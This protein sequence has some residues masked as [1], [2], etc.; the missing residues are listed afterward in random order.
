MNQAGNKMRIDV[1]R[2]KSEKK[3][4]RTE[5]IVSGTIAFLR[6]YNNKC[7]KAFDQAML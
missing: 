2:L 1:G 7:Q 4:R 6:K 5:H 3:K